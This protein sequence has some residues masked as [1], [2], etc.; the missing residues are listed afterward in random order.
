MQIEELGKTTMRF[1]YPLYGLAILL[2]ALTAITF[3]LVS[4]QDGRQLYAVSTAVVGLLSVGGGYFLR[5]KATTAAPVQTTVP[6]PQAAPAEPVQQTAAPVVENPKIDAQAV[7]APKIETPIIEASPIQAA[8]AVEAP[9]VEP[10]AVEAAVAAEAPPVAQV[11]APAAEDPVVEEAISAPVVEAQAAS[12]AAKLEFTQIRGISEKRAEQLKANGINTIEEL[13]NA[14]A[15]D[16]A[17]KLNVSP[18][19]VKMWIGSAKKLSK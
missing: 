18:K 2:F 19:I 13:A 4:D 16:L 1:D 15:V 14:S 7:E 6:T 3:T 5:P 11:V 12:A 17:A 8:P 10:P 9:K